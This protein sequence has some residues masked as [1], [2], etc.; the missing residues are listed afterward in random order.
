MPPLPPPN[1]ALTDILLAAAG[2]VAAIVGP[3]GRIRR[4]G[5]PGA[6]LAG[7]DAARLVDA[8]CF[9]LLAPGAW[10]DRLRQAL[11]TVLGGAAPPEPLEAD[12]LTADGQ[13]RLV[14][15]LAALPGPDG[16]PQAALLSGRLAPPQLPPLS[17][18]GC[19]NE[20]DYRAVFNAASDAIFIQDGDTGR[21]LDANDRTISLFGYSRE[22]LRR[23]DPGG[24]SPGY[25][26][27]TAADA[28]ANVR[29]AAAGQPRLFE[30]LSRDKGGRLFWVEVSLR[31]MDVGRTGRV[32]AVVRDIAERK[33]T[34]RALRESEKKFRQ[35]AEAI[36]EVFWLGSPDWRRV[37]YISPAY[38]R[39]WGRSVK[40]LYEAPMSWIEAVHPDDRDSVLDYIAG[41]AGKPLRPGVFPE[42]RL[43][44]PDGSLRWIQA[45]IFPVAD[46][47][48]LVY[49]VAGIAEDIT[50]RVLARQ[51][52]E[53]VNER[54]E[55]MVRERTQIGRAHV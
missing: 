35:L 51:D 45:R 42:Y 11:E 6:A 34:E 37:F 44:R 25:P 36:G 12:L 8:D 33:M 10:R 2:D 13:V 40:S 38:E 29:L 21:F 14:W 55:D 26:P 54:L 19:Q 18:R 31:A 48:G 39:L 16:K 9:G 15:T 7:S 50:D 20:A 3:S 22:E 43:Q 46:D 1:D 27:F 41:L 24:L 17:E 4:I 49:R 47:A 28:L 52:L 23:L 53:R 30:W 32:I 5:A